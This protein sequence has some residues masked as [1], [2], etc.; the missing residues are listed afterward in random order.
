MKKQ[1]RRDFLKA[2]GAGAAALS[3]PGC[4]DN[5][6]E[7]ERE[8]PNILFIMANDH[9]SQAISS[10][11]GL[12]SSHFKTPNFDRIADEG[13]R[14]SNC[15]CTN[16]ICAPSRATILTGKYSHLNGVYD[17]SF[18][19]DGSQAT[20]PKLLQISGYETAF[21]GKW[22]LKSDPTGFD[23]WIRLPGQGEYY[24]PDFIEMGEKKKHERYVTDLITNFGIEWL[25]NRNK[26]RPYCLMMHHK[27]PH[28][29]WMP[30]GKHLKL[31]EDIDLHMPETFQDDY[32]TRS[33]AAKR[34][35]M[36]ITG[37]MNFAYDL[38]YTGMNETEEPDWGESLMKK[39]FE[40]MD[41]EQLKTWNDAYS[42]GNREFKEADLEG[43]E[44]SNFIYQKYIKDYLRCV[45]S[46]DEN[47]GRVLDYLDESGRSDNT[48]VTYTS[49]QGFYLGEHGW[50]DKR[51]MYEESLRMPLV[52]RY[53]DFISEG[54]VNTDIVLNIDF[55]PTLLSLAGVSPPDEMQ[56]EAFKAGLQGNMPRDWQSSMYYHYYEF[57]AVH[58]VKRHYGIR[59]NRYKLIHFYYDIDVWELYDLRDDPNELNNLY[60]NENYESIVID[61]KKEL[62]ELR[63]KYGDSD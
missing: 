40:R 56:G 17:N 39:Q 53:P 45:K 37:H 8:K 52:V 9:A 10:Y 5:K 51:F 58:Q 33:D 31:F 54:K 24:N 55:A 22:H 16:S 4:M 15:F 18:R 20:F 50:Y 36:S 27:A 1:N 28:R 62:L 48:V 43:D 46:V 63:E 13:I 11:G 14:F 59:T 3:V 44:V 57:P 19:F 25:N 32:S 38:K 60:D 12:L 34:Q 6:N 23:Y 49:D 21:V 41:Q 61:L 35:E 29:N 47:I 2:L 30:D 42:P 7:S 26:S